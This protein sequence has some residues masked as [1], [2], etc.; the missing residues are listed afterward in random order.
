MA[1][2]ASGTHGCTS[3]WSASPRPLWEGGR[4]SPAMQGEMSCGAPWEQGAGVSGTTSLLDLEA[5]GLV[6]DAGG[7]ELNTKLAR[8]Q[9]YQRGR[10][11]RRRVAK[12]SHEERSR[13]DRGRYLDVIA[14]A[15]DENRRGLS[16]VS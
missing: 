5:P 10:R 7:I 13:V 1:A 11:Q 16:A 12:S 8:R 15:V 9:G 3:Q 4:P 6:P 2:L 14:E